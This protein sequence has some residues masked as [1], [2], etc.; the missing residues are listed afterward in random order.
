MEK[1][2][3]LMGSMTNIPQNNKVMNTFLAPKSPIHLYHLFGNAQ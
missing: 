2:K 1:L 3:S